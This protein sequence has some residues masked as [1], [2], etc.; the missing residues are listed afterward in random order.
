MHVA[1]FTC[2]TNCDVN[3]LSDIEQQELAKPLDPQLLAFV[4]NMATPASTTFDLHTSVGASYTYAYNLCLGIITGC[5]LPR[6]GRGVY[7]KAQFGI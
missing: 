7:T 5:M 4:T 2:G 1:S 6:D 3:S